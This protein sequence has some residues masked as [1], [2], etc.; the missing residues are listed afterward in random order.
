ME[1]IKKYGI[2][3]AVILPVGLLVLLRLSGTGHFHGNTVK[4]AE[5]SLAQSNIIT[6]NTAGSIPGEKLI[7]NLD[8]NDILN[9]INGTIVKIP[10]DSI[11][12]DENLAILGNH[13]GPVL[14]LS[15]QESLSARI[16]MILSQLGFKDLYI[17][18]SNTEN[19]VQKNKF[20][21]DTLIRPE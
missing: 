4:L 2:I 17:L 1:L 15:G 11:L 5:P 19:E 9:D 7:I 10:A 20:R 8:N 12:S 13:S 18:A 6:K 16:W 14:L 3:I 21:P